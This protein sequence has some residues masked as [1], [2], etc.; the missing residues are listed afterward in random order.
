MSSFVQQ[1][2]RIE[3]LKFNLTNNTSKKKNFLKSSMYLVAF[4]AAGILFQVSCSN[5]DDGMANINPNNPNLN[6]VGKIIYFHLEQDVNN[7]GIWTCNYDGTGATQIPI[8]LPANSMFSM[9]NGD[10][11]PRLSPDGQKV[12]FLVTGTINSNAGTSIY[13][14]NIDGS[15]LQPIVIANNSSELIGG[16]Y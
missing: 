5:S 13:S 10:P 3:H 6:N 11:R 9:D 15:N 8:I 4:A 14:C 2:I 1:N 7:R 12:F 16:V